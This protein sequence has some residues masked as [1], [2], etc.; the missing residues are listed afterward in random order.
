MNCVGGDRLDLLHACKELGEV[1]S[2]RSRVPFETLWKLPLTSNR[3]ADQHYSTMRK[4]IGEVYEA[5]VSA[6]Q[7]GEVGEGVLDNLLTANEEEDPKSRMTKE[8]ILDQIATF[9][10]GSF[11]TTG[12]TLAM[13]LNH[14]ALNPEVQEELAASLAEVDFSQQT[15]ASLAGLEL[16]VAVTEE[17][18]RLTPTAPAFPRTAV[19]DT[20]IC[21]G[22]YTVKKGA[23]CILDWSVASLDSA[24]WPGQTSEDLLTFRPH[25]W[26]ESKPAKLAHLPFGFGSRMCPGSQLATMEMRLVLGYLIQ[27]IRVAPDPARPMEYATKLALGPKNGAWLSVSLR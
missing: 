20:A 27:K 11:D 8:E 15:A 4:E 18:N 12:N 13:A 7:K 2:R 21:G 16:L 3:E 19:R 9:F 26:L 14:L 10:F 6:I 1:I 5:R 17:T 24:H 25:R 22:K 23:A